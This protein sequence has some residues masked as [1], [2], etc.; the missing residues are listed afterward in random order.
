MITQRGGYKY[1]NSFLLFTPENMGEPAMALCYL[2]TK[3]QFRLTQPYLC[4]FL[5]T[6]NFVHYNTAPGSLKISKI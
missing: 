4:L 6:I 5:L 1:L 3:P 2:F